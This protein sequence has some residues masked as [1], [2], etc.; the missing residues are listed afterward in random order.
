M[1]PYAQYSGH[2]SS[3]DFPQMGTQPN[4]N[5]NHHPTT[6]YSTHQPTTQAFHGTGGHASS[7]YRTPAQPVPAA[8]HHGQQP[9]QRMFPNK[10]HHVSDTADESGDLLPVSK[11]V[12][13]RCFRHTTTARLPCRTGNSVGWTLSVRTDHQFVFYS[14]TPVDVSLGYAIQIPKGFLGRICGR[15]YPFAIPGLIVREIFL[16]SESFFDVTVTVV[17]VTDEPITLL[18]GSD[19]CNLFISRCTDAVVIVDVPVSKVTSTNN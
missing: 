14:R 19:L 13:L 4:V 6:S 10:R 15:P 3:Y 18:P 5:Q 7:S 8:V 11:R 17:N 12:E 2:P 9:V 1:D 16:D